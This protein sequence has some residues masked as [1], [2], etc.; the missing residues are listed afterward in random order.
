[1]NKPDTANLQSPDTLVK[2]TVLSFLEA[3]NRADFSA[4]RKCLS[5]DLKFRGVM[6]DR[7]GAD[8]YI[9]DMKRMKFKYNIL[10]MFVEWRDVCLICDITMSGQVI[11]ACCLYHVKDG[12]ITSINVI[13][14]PRPLL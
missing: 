1:M 12:Q 10:Q 9:D 13:F 5:L 8:V 7:D 6:G 4:A 2:K 3:L 14:D 11:R